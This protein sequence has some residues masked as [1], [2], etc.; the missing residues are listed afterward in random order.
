VAFY[1]FISDGF[2]I[3]MAY[4]LTVNEMA[5]HNVLPCTLCMH[6]TLLL[7]EKY[8]SDHT[9]KSS[10]SNHLQFCFSLNACLHSMWNSPLIG[11]FQT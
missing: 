6:D 11:I 9:K 10:R 7:L 1:T 4:K 8:E 5:L 2:K 3:T